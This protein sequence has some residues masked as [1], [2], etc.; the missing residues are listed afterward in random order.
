MAA[1]GF[2]IIELGNQEVGFWNCGLLVCG[3]CG[4]SDDGLGV[5]S[6]GETGGGG[7]AANPNMEANWGADNKG[8]P[9]SEDVGEAQ[10]EFQMEDGVTVR[11]SRRRRS[12]RRMN[13]ALPSPSRGPVR[14]GA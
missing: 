13:V 6:T 1:D 2:R 12:D 4:E 7:Q 9:Y 8:V 11:C 14:S 10:M 5:D 3:P